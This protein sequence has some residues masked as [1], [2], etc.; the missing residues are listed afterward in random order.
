M[1]K[2]IVFWRFK[3][4]VPV[5]ARPAALRDIKQKFEALNGAIPGLIRLEIGGDFGGSP[6]SSDFVLY[7]EFETREALD[8][9]QAHPRH[10]E[11]MP[12]IGEVRAERRVVDYD[13]T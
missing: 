4:S 10:R 2:H 6:D 5:D 9:Y 3:N 13:V 7:S 12:M 11:L 8:G 1:V